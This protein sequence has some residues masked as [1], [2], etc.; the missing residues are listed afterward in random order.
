MLGRRDA[1]ACKPCHP[2]R[3]RNEVAAE[4]RNPYSNKKPAS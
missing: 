4:S 1:S 2:E 3:S